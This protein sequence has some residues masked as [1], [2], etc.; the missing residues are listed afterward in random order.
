[1]A[2][3][4]IVLAQKCL[5]LLLTHAIGNLLHE[6][7]HSYLATLLT[8][9]DKFSARAA[10]HGNALPYHATKAAEAALSRFPVEFLR[11][12]FLPG[13]LHFCFDALDAYDPSSF[14]DKYACRLVAFVH[15]VVECTAYDAETLSQEDLGR[16]VEVMQRFFSEQ[17]CA[18]LLESLVTRVLRLSQDE[19]ASWTED[20]EEFIREEDAAEWNA[21]N[22]RTAAERLVI[23]LMSK[24]RS[25]LAAHLLSMTGEACRRAD[26]ATLVD[27]CFRAIGRC[28]YEL[29]NELSFSTW[30][31]EQLAPILKE[32]TNERDFSRQ[33]IKA[34]AAKL[35]GQFVLAADTAI[36]PALYQ[37]LVPLLTADS[38]NHL[39]V[40]LSSVRALH[41]L[42]DDLGF[43]HEQF[44]EFTGPCLAGV[45]LLVGQ[46]RDADTQQGLLTFAGV[47]IER[48]PAMQTRP[49]LSD[50]ANQIGNLLTLA[51][52]LDDAGD[53]DS[54]SVLRCGTVVLATKILDFHGSVA[55]SNPELNSYVVPLIEH[56]LD[57][58]SRTGGAI[59]MLDDGERGFRS[60]RSRCWATVDSVACRLRSLD[61]AHPCIG[62]AYPADCQS[63]LAFA[64]RLPL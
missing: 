46:C 52:N 63:C 38:T 29:R 44:A 9:S 62:S 19:I 24:R 20:P 35:I 32:V 17:R 28:A 1:V 37:T 58:T 25:F 57:K 39:V 6:P 51:K 49:F 40:R 7:V 60:A 16:Y 27:A 4:S 26:S 2:L 41:T 31:N 36:R 23:G 56:A 14:S 55:A 3:D 12:G 18:L 47:M 42:V 61:C 13:F 5:N 50:L 53:R 10:R 22:P 48:L 11:G 8:D 33:V 21:E 64:V 34:R 15:A 54:S 45:F 59:Y 30:F 43:E